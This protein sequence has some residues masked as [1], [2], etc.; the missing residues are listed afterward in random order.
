[1]VYAYVLQNVQIGIHALQRSTA[2]CLLAN[3]TM[4]GN[5]KQHMAVLIN[6][7]VHKPNIY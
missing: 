4:P 3:M 2:G 6:T 5:K 7:T 1:M